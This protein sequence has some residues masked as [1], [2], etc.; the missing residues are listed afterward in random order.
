M[1]SSVDQQ[2]YNF[3]DFRDEMAN[4]ENR[5]LEKKIADKKKEELRQKNIA[6]ILKAASSKQT[7]IKI[8]F[9]LDVRRLQKGAEALSARFGCRGRGG[10]TSESKTR[11][12]SVVQPGNIFKPFK[13]FQNSRKQSSQ[14]IWSLSF[15]TGEHATGGHRPLLC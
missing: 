7:E 1:S 13:Y 9:T 10:N 2:T 4:I 14:T 11:R 5:I 15:R 6:V 8:F 12:R 3:I